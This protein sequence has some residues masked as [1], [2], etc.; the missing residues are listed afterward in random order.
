MTHPQASPQ[1]AAQTRPT[2]AACR[3]VPHCGLQ[4]LERQ[5]S[6]EVPAGYMLV[7]HDASRDHWPVSPCTENSDFDHNNI[8]GLHKTTHLRQTP[9]Y[10]CATD[11]KARVDHG[12]ARCWA[13][14]CKQNDSSMD[15]CADAICLRHALLW[16][17][18]R[19]HNGPAHTSADCLLLRHRR[20]ST[21]DAMTPSR[22][23]SCNGL[24]GKEKWADS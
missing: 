7:K 14:L 6:R 10:Q 13:T 3:T 9:R 16:Q 20:C 21:A 18:V 15:T 22:Q 17:S 11:A 12:H 1:K 4:A 8:T 23:L 19:M 2:A 24:L 5:C